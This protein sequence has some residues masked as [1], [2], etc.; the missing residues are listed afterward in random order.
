M[1]FAFSGFEGFEKRLELHFFGDD[2][3]ILQLGLRK[4]SFECIQQ[5]LEAVQCTVVSAVGNSYF[6]A[7]VLSESSLFVYPT[8]IIIKTCGTTQLLKSITP[9]IFYAQTHLGLTLSLCRYTRGSFIFP[10]SQPFPHTSF[11]HEVTYL[12]TTLPSDLCFRKAS[13]MPSKSSSHAWHVFTATNIPHHHSRALYSE[14][15]AYTME[16]CMTDLDPVLAR[17]FF[18]RAGD[19]KT[20]DSAGKEM[21]ELTGVDEIN[22]QALVCDFAFDPCGY[23]MN[24]IDGEWY[25]TIHVTPEDGY[26]YASFECVGS[27][28]D[29]VD[30]L[31]VLRKVVQ[32][33]RPGTMS[34]STT[35][36]GSEM[37]REVS[38]AVEPMG[39]KLRSC[40]MDQFPD[41]GSVVFQTFT[42]LRRKSAH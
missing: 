20:G 8:K 29:D 21:T 33:F 9:L 10:L 17:K 28:N 40:A 5:T 42:P 25:S 2:P 1:A 12:E 37:W 41:S 4:L 32:I 13:I 31:H 26:S 38:G 14:S 11:E 23:S 15:H 6:D 24:G 16:I 39:M 3:T 34:V 18:R 22:P 7:Y 35:S 36:L 30:I 27:V 19:G